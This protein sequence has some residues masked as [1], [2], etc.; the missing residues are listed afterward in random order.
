[1]IVVLTAVMSHLVVLLESWRRLYSLENGYM[2]VH[3]VTFFLVLLQSVHCVK[4]LYW[5]E[6]SKLRKYL[7]CNYFWL[8]YNYETTKILS[9][10]TLH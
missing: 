8:I 1:M 2:I 3:L 9:E 4:K 5:K 6:N 7:P 10:M